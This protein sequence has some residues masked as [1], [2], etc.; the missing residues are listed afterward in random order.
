MFRDES[1]KIK[2]KKAIKV[3]A[4]I[5][6]FLLIATGALIFFF[7]YSKETNCDVG[8][9]KPIGSNQ[10]LS[11]SDGCL[12]C[13]S[14]QNNACFSCSGKMY[15]VLLNQNDTKGSCETTCVGTVLKS[16]LCLKSKSPK[17]T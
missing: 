9:F 10:C 4:F 13:E 12:R 1:K 15:L 17:K 8:T 2:R 7:Y 6:M 5:M 11:C 14:E 16:N 3:S